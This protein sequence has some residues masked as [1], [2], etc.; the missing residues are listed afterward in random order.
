M[1]DDGSV[2]GSAD[3][4]EELGTAVRCVRRPP[5]GPGAA[6]NHGVSI[7][8][9][10]LIAFLDADDV[11]VPDRLALQLDR[12]RADPHLQL[13]DGWA[14]NFWSPDVP[15]TE[16]RPAPQEVH[17]H[18]QAPQGGLPS[19]WLVR[20]ALFDAV[21]GFD[22][23]LA[24]GEDSE[25]RDRVDRAAA[26]CVTVDGILAWR[27]LHT[28]NVTRMRYDEHLRGVVRRVRGKL[29]DVR[30]DGGPA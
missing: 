17:T 2:D 8:R 21:G 20:R 7:A 24:L 30:S 26:R 4:A 13:C 18:G 5:G 29:L 1:V 14:R 10:D 28:A 15:E 27:R 6:R 25:W 11:A 12:F 3:I 19:T 9:G 23:E 16:R 22:E